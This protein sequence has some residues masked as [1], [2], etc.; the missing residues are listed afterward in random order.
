MT[1]TGWAVKR[2]EFGTQ[3]CPIIFETPLTSDWGKA[4]TGII[5][6]SCFGE[7]GTESSRTLTLE[8][9]EV[10]SQVGGGDLLLQYV[11]FVE[12]EDDGCVFEPGQLQDRA[13]EGQALLHSVLGRGTKAAHGSG[14]PVWLNRS[15][16]STR[17]WSRGRAAG[18]LCVPDMVLGLTWV[19]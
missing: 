17:R 6:G 3:A 2:P 18:C 5:L 4:W 1:E 8:T 16:L 19:D 7:A 11:G 15:P 9:G 12:E 14:W 10:G 13:E